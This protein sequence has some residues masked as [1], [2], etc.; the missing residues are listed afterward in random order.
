MLRSLPLQGGSLRPEPKNETQF[1]VGSYEGRGA[2]DA[3]LLRPGCLL[4]QAVLD[5]L[6]ATA[7]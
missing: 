5:D 7:R 3:N 1:P 6:L 4:P 2:E